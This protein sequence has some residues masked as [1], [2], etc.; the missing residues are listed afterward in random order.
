MGQMGTFDIKTV[1]WGQ[2]FFSGCL[3]IP[4]LL[5]TTQVLSTSDQKIYY[6]LLEI[7]HNVSGSVVFTV[8][9]SRLMIKG[10][11]TDVWQLNLCF[12]Q[13]RSRNDMFVFFS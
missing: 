11:V 10:C 13:V 12:Y 5:T 6:A 2:V 7:K 9:I 1:L 8:K 3:S 4:L